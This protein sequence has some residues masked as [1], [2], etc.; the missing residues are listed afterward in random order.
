MG[1]IHKQTFLQQFLCSSYYRFDMFDCQMNLIHPTRFPLCCTGE[2]H[3]FDTTWWWVNDKWYVFGWTTCF[4]DNLLKIKISIKIWKYM[5]VLEKFVWQFNWILIKLYLHVS[6]VGHVVH[7][8][9]KKIISTRPSGSSSTS[10]E[11]LK[12]STITRFYRKYNAS[13]THYMC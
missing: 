13:I 10:N 5:C 9:N 2:S 11:C 3:R 12:Y 7:Y 6:L 8:E 1:F 4:L